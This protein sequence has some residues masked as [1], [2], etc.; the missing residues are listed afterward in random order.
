MTYKSGH[1]ARG[2]CPRGF[3]V[4]LARLADFVARNTDLVSYNLSRFWSTRDTLRRFQRK[5]YTRSL[6]LPESPRNIRGPLVRALILE[7]V[8]P[9]GDGFSAPPPPPGRSI[10]RRRSWLQ[11]EAF[12]LG[13]SFLL[14]IVLASGVWPGSRA[15]KVPRDFFRGC[16][17]AR[18][19]LARRR[20]CWLKLAELVGDARV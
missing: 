12:Y 18:S 9:S 2:S 10:D 13:A 3:F 1:R 8:C 6:P 15:K 14:A 19:T 11:A 20:R 4:D 7:A 5:T 16:C 17:A